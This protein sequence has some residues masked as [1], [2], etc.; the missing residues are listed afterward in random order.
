MRNTIS[1]ATVKQAISPASLYEFELPGFRPRRSTGWVDGGLCPF[2]DDHN[3]PNL[4]ISP[5]KGLFHCMACGAAGNAI[6]FVEKFDGVSFRHAFETL[7][8]GPAAYSAPAKGN[9]L[10]NYCQLGP[11]LLEYAC[12]RAPLK[13]GTYTPG[14]HLPVID[15]AE[16]MADPPDVFLLLAWNFK[17]ELIAKNLAY[18]ERGGQF[19]VPIPQPHLV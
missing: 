14:M 8:E 4:I 3:T 11:D 1:A 12:E 9:T 2:H 17:D 6:Q 13:I 5:D 16:A 18:R 7:N 10:L 15:E 19:L